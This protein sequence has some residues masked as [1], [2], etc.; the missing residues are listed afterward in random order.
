MDRK[1]WKTKITEMTNGV[2]TY[3]PEFDSIIETLADILEQRDAAFADY[4]ESGAETV[5]V[6]VSDRGSESIVK[7]P[8]LQVW[9]DLNTQAL[10]YWRDLGLTPA[11]L[12]KIKESALNT[13]VKESA[14]EAAL[15]SIGGPKLADSKKI[16]GTDKGRKKSSVRRTKTSRK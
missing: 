5:I 11:G 8:R 12:K 15:K 2:G 1:A 10:S 16:R 9:N 14:L 3:K 13:D 7:N 6:H 4:I